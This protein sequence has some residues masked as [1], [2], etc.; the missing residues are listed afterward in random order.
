[1]IEY[2]QWRT[3]ARL[4]H[5][6]ESITFDFHLPAGMPSSDL[7]IYPRYLE[8][9]APGDSFCPGEN[10]DWLAALPCQT[11]KLRIVGG[12]ATITYKPRSA[13]S[14]LAAWQAGHERM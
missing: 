4:L 7:A 6:G 5:R 3:G 1:M 9:A 10:L 14:Y 8:R 2:A 11:R 13:G 12:R